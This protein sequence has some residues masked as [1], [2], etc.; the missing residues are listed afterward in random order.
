MTF[1]HHNAHV[2]HVSPYRRYL[3]TTYGNGPSFAADQLTMYGLR[4]AWVCAR[5]VI[6][7]SRSHRR[8]LDSGWK[9]DI[10]W[11]MSSGPS[12]RPGTIG[13]RIP[14][15]GN[16]RTGQGSQASGAVGVSSVR[17]TRNILKWVSVALLLSFVVLAF[18]GLR[19]GSWR[20]ELNAQTDIGWQILQDQQE[21]FV[22]IRHSRLTRDWAGD[23]M[24][25]DPDEWEEQ[26]DIENGG[27]M[28][29]EDGGDVQDEQLGSESSKQEGGSQSSEISESSSGSVQGSSV[30]EDSSLSEE[31]KR[32]L[33]QIRRR[34]KV[35]HVPL[36]RNPMR[37]VTP[38]QLLEM[39]SQAQKS[40]P[41]A[42]EHNQLRKLQASAPDISNVQKSHQGPSSGSASTG[43]NSPSLTTSTSSLLGTSLSR[44]SHF[45]PPCSPKTA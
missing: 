29:D 16:S 6:D 21:P 2:W 33:E 44:L 12:I 4:Y 26:G 13:T 43:K 34:Q 3:N 24:E 32:R 5:M 23:E 8:V 14:Q 11:E 42:A 20:N 25:G 30:S 38:K 39:Y 28:Q 18:T 7:R 31:S 15:G 36:E 10:G 45:M 22:N 41:A 35:M 9:R 19:R 40:Y 1:C 37:N 27:D 17:Q